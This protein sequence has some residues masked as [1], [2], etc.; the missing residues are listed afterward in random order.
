MPIAGILAGSGVIKTV[1]LITPTHRGDL[2]RFSLLCDSIDRFV[3]GYERHY[4]IVNDDDVPFFARFENDRRTV[5]P[6]SRFLP[7]WLKQLPPFLLRKGRRTWWSFRTAPL[8]GWHI[9]QILKISGI[10]QLPE[11][12]YCI[13]D[14]DNVFFRPFDVAGY[15]GADSIPLYVDRQAIRAE[16]PLHSV[17]IRNCDR[18]L[19]GGTT[20]TFPADDYIGNGIV[21]DKSTL[22]DMTATIEVAT[23]TPWAE[24][25]C[26]TRSFSEYI[27]YGYFV[28]R[29]P[30]HRATHR[31]TMQSLATSHWEHDQLD[32][33]A[34]QAMVDR[35]P[36]DA[37]ALCIESFSLTPVSLIRD[38]VGLS[39]CGEPLQPQ[40]SDPASAP[41]A[42]IAPGIREN[43]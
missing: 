26:K 17:W 29:S 27:I 8:H 2:D 20:T 22:R 24:A 35:S 19:G 36:A 33:K 41:G 39:D 10:L 43:V 1:A 34:L 13:I 40:C 9:Q 7:P 14:S 25:L 5:L 6:G 32:A 15:A 31:L 30:V 37:V 42:N 11:Q 23:G 21:W 3:S 16:S 18:L 4:V 12:R 28:S 38:V